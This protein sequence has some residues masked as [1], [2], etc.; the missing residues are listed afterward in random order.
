MLHTGRSTRIVSIQFRSDADATVALNNL[1]TRRN[2]TLQPS[3]WC[4]I[5]VEPCAVPKR[6]GV[7]DDASGELE[8]KTRVSHVLSNGRPSTIGKRRQRDD[9]SDESDSERESLPPSR[10]TSALRGVAEQPSSYKTDQ[11]R[12]SNVKTMRLGL[13]QESPCESRST[14]DDPN[15]DSNEESNE[16]TEYE[17]P[18]SSES[19]SEETT[20]SHP[21]GTVL[22]STPDGARLLHEIT[23]CPMPRVQYGRPRRLL[24]PPI[25]EIPM[26]AATMRADLQHIDEKG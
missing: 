22:N 6:F 14:G 25:T 16:S 13:H 1:I 3:W 17:S 23:C 18:D 15:P 19:D 10:H 9:D 12:R 11:S 20:P 26:V 5:V 21:R 4:R 8:D 7:N 2:K 24:V